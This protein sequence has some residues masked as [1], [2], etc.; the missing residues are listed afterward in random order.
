MYVL[1]FSPLLYVYAFIFSPIVNKFTCIIQISPPLTKGK[2]KEKIQIQ[3]DQGCVLGI[4]IYNTLP[5]NHT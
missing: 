4:K 5:L 1:L 3:K 2:K